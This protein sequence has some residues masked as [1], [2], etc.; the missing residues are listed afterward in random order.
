M[1][2]LKLHKKLHK[3]LLAT[4]A[5]LVAVG[6]ASSALAQP[7]FQVDPTTYYPSGTQF[8]ATDMTGNSSELLT[9]NGCGA[10]TLCMAGGSTGWLN[11]ASFSN[12]GPLGT[13]GN[14]NNITTAGLGAY[15]LYLTYNFIGTLTGGTMGQPGSSYDVG[16]LTYSLYIDPGAADTFNFASSAGSGT[17]ASVTPGGTAD[18]LLGSGHVLPGGVAGI[19]SNFGAHLTSTNTFALTPAGSAYF[20]DP[21]PFYN[22]AFDAFN[23]TSHA[24]T[25]N[26]T[27]GLVAINAAGTVN[28]GAVP[29]PEPETL[30]LLGVGLLGMGASLRKRKAA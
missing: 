30:A 16:S 4:A 12:S 17:N 20:V 3:K 14:V 2:T 5:G 8:Y 25:V 24:V 26:L 23:N 22:V 9:M 15:N 27:N 10:G 11:I 18:I 21:V 1:K 6:M 28:F 13:L 7:Q 29:V 19:D